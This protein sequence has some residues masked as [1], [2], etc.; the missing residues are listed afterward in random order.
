MKC[1]IPLVRIHPFGIITIL[2]FINNL[3]SKVVC[4]HEP[5]SGHNIQVRME[6]WSD[7]LTRGSE[8]K[9]RGVSNMIVTTRPAENANGR[10]DRGTAPR[11]AILSNLTFVSV[12]AKASRPS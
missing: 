9:L 6:K 1:R 4:V 10:G 7:S 11:P 3:S 12:V 2:Q 8:M 5:A